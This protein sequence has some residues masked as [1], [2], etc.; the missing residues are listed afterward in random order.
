MDGNL[1]YKP[2]LDLPAPKGKAAEWALLRL[3]ATLGVPAVYD[4]WQDLAD[5]IAA[6]TMTPRKMDQPTQKRMRKKYCQEQMNVGTFPSRKVKP[7]LLP[8]QWGD[9]RQI[10]ALRPV[11]LGQAWYVISID[12]GMEIGGRA[13]LFRDLLEDEIYPELEDHF[14]LFMND[15]D[16]DIDL[17]AEWP[18]VNHEGGH[19]WWL[20]TEEQAQ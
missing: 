1:K 16:E 4:T 3:A 7:E 6:T 2:P 20:I 5:A 9:G 11:I 15:T 18:A 17:F 19:E 14:G 8:V 12:S 10:I 13:N